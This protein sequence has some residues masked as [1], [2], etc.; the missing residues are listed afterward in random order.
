MALS[1]GPKV[2][3]NGLVLALDAADK[4]SYPGSGATWRDLS[5]NGNNSTLTN[6]PTFSSAGRGSIV[7]DG[8]DDYTTIPVQSS[9]GSICFWYYYNAGTIQSLIMGNASSMI[10][11]GGGAGSGHWFNQTADYSFVFYWPNVSQWLYMC[12]TYT[13][14]TSNSMYIN[15]TL[16]YSSNTYNLPKGTTYNVAGNYYNPQNCRFSSISVYNRSLTA[17][18]VLQNYNATKSRFGLI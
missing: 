18:E 11:C 12:G 9:V 16:A 14:A 2:V 10:Y 15:G 8:I 5:G 7:F 1:R 13:S 4:N 6:G 3:T 17:T